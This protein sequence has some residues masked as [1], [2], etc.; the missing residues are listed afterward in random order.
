MIAKILQYDRRFRI[1]GNGSSGF[2]D[3][4]FT[5]STLIP[6]VRANWKFK[7]EFYSVTSKI[8]HTIYVKSLGYR[9][10]A[11]VDIDVATEEVRT[12]TIKLLSL[13]SE[14]ANLPTGSNN[15]YLTFF[16]DTGL[17]ELISNFYC[18]SFKQD[19]FDKNILLGERYSFVF[20]KRNL[21]K[22]LPL[23]VQYL[24]TDTGDYIVTDT[25][26]RIILGG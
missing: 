2:T 16:K 22:T 23:F 17:S 24:Q 18:K 21:I 19:D 26:N 7:E 20:E 10:T 9:V 1:F 12:E 4:D 11:N 25:G 13:I 8:T 14:N 5:P 15:L 6:Y 3:I